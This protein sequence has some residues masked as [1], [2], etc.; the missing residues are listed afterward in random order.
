MTFF[1][2]GDSSGY[3]RNG[4]RLAWTSFAQGYLVAAV[5]RNGAGDVYII[6][7]ASSTN[8]PLALVSRAWIQQ[9]NNPEPW[10]YYTP[11]PANW[12]A[13]YIDLTTAIVDP[14]ERVWLGSHPRQSGRKNWVFDFRTSPP[15]TFEWEPSARQDPGTCFDDL[16]TGVTSWDIDSQGY[17]WVGAHNGAYYTQSGVPGDL[18]SLHFVCV[19]D[20]PVGQSVNAVHVDADDNKWFGTDDGVAVMDKN[21][22]WAHVFKTSDAEENRS[23]LASNSVTSITSNPETGDIW[24]GT[25]DGLSRLQSPYVNRAGGLRD[26]KPYPNPFAADGAHRMFINHQDLGGV[27]DELRVYTLTGRLVRKISWSQAINP[28]VGWDGRNGDGELVAGGVYLLVVS[29]TDGSSATGKVAVLG[30]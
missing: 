11:Y 19:Y 30:K 13:S 20:L 8:K 27:F 23:G 12:E 16:L 10:L 22:T 1:Y 3:D 26:L 5:T 9:G 7:R 4:P 18:N 14:Y 24:I 15:D 17:L 6:N 21:F 29:A 25:T 28:N 2:I